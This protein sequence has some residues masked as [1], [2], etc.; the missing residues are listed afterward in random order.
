MPPTTSMRPYRGLTP[1]ERIEERRQRLLLAGRQCFAEAGNV[2]PEV[3]QVCARA[4]VSKRHFYELYD[5]RLDLVRALHAEAM[6]WFREGFKDDTHQADPVGWLVRVVPTLFAKLLEDP[7]RAH[8][9]ALAPTQG[10]DVSPSLADMIVEGLVRR[11]GDVANRPAASKERVRRHALGAVF[12]G[13]AILAEW[14][15]AA[16]GPARGRVMARYIQDVVSVATGALSPVLS[17]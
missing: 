12:A 17:E 15:L 9:L 4:G 13:R 7:L 10:A 16:Q 6:E 11:V 8:V 5:D 3:G 14:L 1:E 2:G